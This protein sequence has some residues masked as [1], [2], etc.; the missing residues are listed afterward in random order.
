[1][2]IMERL[3]CLAIGYV[4]GLFQTSYIIGR[5]HQTDIREHGSGNAGTTNALRTFGKKAGALTLLGDCLKC[6]V[7]ILIAKALYTNSSADILPLLSLYAAAGCILGHNFPFYLNFRGGKGVAASVGLV[8]AFDW[9]IFLIC[10][11]VFFGL[12]FT[13]HYVS[14]CSISAYLT[15]LICLI[16][17]GELGRYGM[18]RPHT[19]ELYIVMAALTALA[20]YRHRA[21]IVRLFKG[22]ENK[23]FL[24]KSGEKK[25]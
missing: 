6:V 24:G 3:I 17:F 11:V 9:R 21:N 1:M 15:A 5:I 14:L 13:T 25:A 23:I 12:F 18:D 4:C 16:I 10:F 19:I 20:V 2:S 8:I 22:T 7:A